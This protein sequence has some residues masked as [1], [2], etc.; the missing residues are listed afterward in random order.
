MERERLGKRRVRRRGA[1]PDLLELP[2]V[3]PLCRG[4]GLERPGPGDAVL[5]HVEKPVADRRAQP[6][7]QARAV[8]I[9][10]EIAKLEWEVRRSMRAVDDCHDAALARHVAQALNWEE[11]PGQVG[12]VAEMEQF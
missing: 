10:L 4:R 2:D 1:R 5:A 3:L 7:V 6:L 12:D 8:I 9:A 11:L